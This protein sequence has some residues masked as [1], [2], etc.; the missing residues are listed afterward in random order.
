VSS[1]VF[2]QPAPE[3]VALLVGSTLLAVLALLAGT[4]IGA[5]SERLVVGGSLD[6]A[7][8]EGLVPLAAENAPLRRGAG[9]VAVIRL[10]GL[11]P[12]AIALVAA[13]QPLYLAIYQELI[14]PEELRTP[15]L[16]RVLSDIPG[17]LLWLGVAW[18]LGDAAASLSVRRLLL[19]GRSIGAAWALGWLGLVRRPWRVLGTALAT[20]GVLVLLLLPGILGAATGWARLRALLIEGND[21]VAIVLGVVLFVAVWVAGLVLVGAAAAFRGA[22]WTFE[23]VRRPGPSSPHR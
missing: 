14:L 23:L 16:L 11:V 21:P 6:V 19:E 17:A 13:A 8:D 10:L 1:L 4:Y 15:L 20:T 7:A 9:A 2:G 18:L 12:L 5:W 22:A 3:L